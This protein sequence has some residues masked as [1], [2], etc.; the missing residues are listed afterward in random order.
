MIKS[1]QDILKTIHKKWL[2]RFILEILLYAMGGALLVFGL[3]SNLMYSL[4]FFIVIGLILAWMWKPWNYTVSHVCN[5]LDAKQPNMEFSTSLLLEKEEGL[6]LLARLQREK[7][8]KELIETAKTIASERSLKNALIVFFLLIFGAG[9]LNYSGLNN[10]FKTSDQNIPEQRII[11]STADST[12]NEIAP[13]LITAQTLK[14]RYPKYTGQVS[15]STSNMNL[16]ALKGSSMSWSLEFDKQVKSVTIQVFGED[17]A[18]NFSKDNYAFSLKPETSGFYNFRFTD[19]LGIIYFSELYSIELFEDQSPDIKIS[20]LDQFT[21]FDNDQS[22]KLEL[23]ALISDDYGIVTAVI[24]ATVS[25]GSGESVKFR[26]E[27][28]RFDNPIPKDSK[29]VTLQRIIDLDKMQMEPGDELYFYVMANDV[30]SPNANISRGETYFANIRD[31]VSDVFEVEGAMGVDQMPDYFRSQRQLII[32]TEKLIKEKSSLSKNEFNSRSN[33]LAFD[34]KALRIKYGEFMGD[35]STLGANS[36]EETHTEDG[37]DNLLSEYEHAHDT[38]NESNL[39]SD[40]EDHDHDHGEES[41]EETEEDPL[42]EYVHNHDDPEEATLYTKSLKAQLRMALNEMW[43]AELHLRLYHPE[44]SLPVQYRILKRL[45]DIKN[46]ARIYVHRIGFDPLPIKEDKR[47]TGDL[48]EVS[49]YKKTEDLEKPVLYPAIR[50]SIERLEVLISDP[51][52]R[53]D[54][55]KILFEAAGNETA[56]LALAQ[57]VKYLKNLQDLKRL[58]QGIQITNKEMIIVQR[59]LILALPD[60]KSQPEQ[61]SSEIGELNTLFIQELNTYD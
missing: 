18:M 5:Y 34:Q 1:G 20:G 12:Q 13:P 9:F 35:E 37:E 57:P 40:E 54:E 47:L 55:D 8:G 28:L 59:S 56:E 31:T 11:F 26:E 43:D 44:E 7:I 21:S 41:A 10:V 29:K 61:K 27:E 38:E 25:K 50:S 52:L 42:H 16:K 39:V 24:I 23:N 30:K 46:S 15:K 6:S 60:A 51:N 45:Q 2:L 36:S 49:S 3:T 32:D 4:I 48:K 58:S 14:V 19:T 53:T 33:E 22:K 17:K